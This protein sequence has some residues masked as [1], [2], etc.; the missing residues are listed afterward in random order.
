MTD[1]SGI[2]D[3]FL[4]RLFFQPHRNRR[5]ALLLA[6]TYFGLIG[7]VVLLAVLQIDANTAAGGALL[8]LIGKFIGNWGT[9]FDFEFGSSRGSRD[10]DEML[11]GKL[12]PDE[13]K[14]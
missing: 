6:G 9:A 1:P 13:P 7:C 5:A 3:G 14:A 8:L 4:H 12:S 11:A 10:K 2:N